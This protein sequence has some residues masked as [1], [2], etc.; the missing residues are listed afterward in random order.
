M[1]SDGFVMLQVDTSAA[2]VNKHIIFLSGPTLS[3]KKVN[4]NITHKTIHKRYSYPPYI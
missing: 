3:N 4:I 1:A 2:E